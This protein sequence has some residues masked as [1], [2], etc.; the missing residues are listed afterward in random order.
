MNENAENQMTTGAVAT[1]CTLIRLWPERQE[2]SSLQAEIFNSMKL[3]P[4]W[5]WNPPSLLSV[6]VKL[7][8]DFHSLSMI[9]RQA[10]YV[11]RNNEAR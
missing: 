11:Q 3:T 2:L 7:P 5:L 1:V 9:T 6:V 4:K 10:I 8:A